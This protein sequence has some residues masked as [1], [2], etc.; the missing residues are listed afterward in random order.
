MTDIIQPTEGD[1]E[2]LERSFWRFWI[3]ADFIIQNQST[4]RDEQMQEI[5]MWNE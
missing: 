1:M 5:G 3:W 4:P 2:P